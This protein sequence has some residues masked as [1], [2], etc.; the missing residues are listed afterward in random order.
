MFVEWC[1]PKESQPSI[2]TPV[3]HF[4]VYLEIKMATLS[5]FSV[6]YMI[7]LIGVLT[8]KVHGVAFCNRA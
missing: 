7:G 1:T 3:W 8:K 4:V 5:S 2:C 6:E